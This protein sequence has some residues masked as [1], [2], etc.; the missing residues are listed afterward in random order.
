M[1]VFF[2]LGVYLTMCPVRVAPGRCRRCRTLVPAALVAPGRFARGST[3]GYWCFYERKKVVYGSRLEVACF[4]KPLRSPRTIQQAEHPSIPSFSG[5][6]RSPLSPRRREGQTSP[7]RREAIKRFYSL[8]KRKGHKHVYRGD[9]SIFRLLHVD[10]FQASVFFVCCFLCA[11]FFVGLCSFA[12]FS[13]CLLPGKS[14][15]P[16][17]RRPV[18][19]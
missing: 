3:T 16:K 5:G 7:R 8:V 2:F 9:A 18:V 4:V 17:L 12:Y 1:C 6:R 11:Y 10:V 15:R 13:R 14:T 19:W